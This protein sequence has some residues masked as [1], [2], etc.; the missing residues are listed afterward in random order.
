[1]AK[2]TLSSNTTDFTTTLN[3]PIHLGANKKYEAA[4]LSLHTYNSILNITETNNKFKYSRDKGVSWKTI[5]FERGAYELEEINL[6]IRR[7]MQLEITSTST[8]VPE[9][10]IDFYRPTFKSILVISNDNYM[11]D[12]GVEN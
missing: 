4:F 6:R 7:E 3:P 10:E 9:I 1:M 2:L 11:V 8:E 5:T 12:F